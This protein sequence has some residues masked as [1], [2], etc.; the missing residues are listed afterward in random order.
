MTNATKN[1]LVAPDE[2]FGEVYEA[3]GAYWAEVIHKED[4]F[5]YVVEQS[6]DFSSREQALAWL[7]ERDVPVYLGLIEQTLEAFSQ[8]SFS[9]FWKRLS[10]TPVVT[11]R[12]AK[13]A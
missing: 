8:V 2:V 11:G 3:K 9:A 4:G 5:D 13:M 10:G 6:N 12:V 7:G 1:T